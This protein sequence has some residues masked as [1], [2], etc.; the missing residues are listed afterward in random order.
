MSFA[1][2]RS[3]T[4]SFPFGLH[5]ALFALLIGYLVKMVF[6]LPAF[7]RAFIVFFVTTFF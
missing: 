5:V 7:L 4:I 3:D 2:P 6:A 1:S